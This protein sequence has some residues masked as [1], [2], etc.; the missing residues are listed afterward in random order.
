M[1]KDKNN[2]TVARLFCVTPPDEA[3][4]RGFLDFLRAKYGECEL[5]IIE[6][7]AL[8]GGFKLQV[9][10]DVYDWSIKGRVEQLKAGLATES[11][12]A[13]KI[14]PLLKEKLDLD[15]FVD[16]SYYEKAVKS[17]DK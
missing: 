17:L 13:D 5:E 12:S 7:P 11:G 1:K 4:K 14:I 8:G 9:G 10:A 15:G 6:D 16:T 2:V 3:R